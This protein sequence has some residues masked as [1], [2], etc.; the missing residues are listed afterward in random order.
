MLLKYLLEWWLLLVTVTSSAAL[1]QSDNLRDA[2]GLAFVCIY[3]SI[4]YNCFL[5]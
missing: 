4:S 3:K 5:L 1:L 2:N